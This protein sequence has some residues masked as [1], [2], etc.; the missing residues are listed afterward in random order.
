MSYF[1]VTPTGKIQ[2]NWSLHL[3]DFFFLTDM[4]QI[5]LNVDVLTWFRTVGWPAADLGGLQTPG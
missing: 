1:N 4:W 2:E 5:K 3:R